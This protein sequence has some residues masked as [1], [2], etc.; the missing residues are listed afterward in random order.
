MTTSC[1]WEGKGRYSSFRLW[2]KRIVCTVQVKLWYPLTMRA[3]PERLRDAS[4]GGA[5]QI[6]DL[7]EADLHNLAHEA[8]SIPPTAGF[9]LTVT[10]SPESIHLSICTSFCRPTLTNDPRPSLVGLFSTTPSRYSASS[11]WLTWCG[12]T[13][14]FSKPSRQ[15]HQ[16]QNHTHIHATLGYSLATIIANDAGSSTGLSMKTSVDCQS[17]NNQHRTAPAAT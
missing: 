16:S 9:I 1:G 2:M 3:I 8:I 13:N 4:C 11:D 10:L 6:D 7:Y 5:I 15:L 17:E 14:G 12:H